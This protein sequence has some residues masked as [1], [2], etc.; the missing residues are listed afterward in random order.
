MALSILEKEALKNAKIKIELR[1]KE[2]SLLLLK[3]IE[4]N[5]RY[6]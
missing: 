5:N 1:Q 2:I 6:G 4:W 3:H